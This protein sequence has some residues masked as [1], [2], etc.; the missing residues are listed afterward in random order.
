VYALTVFERE[1]RS[2]HQGP[3]FTIEDGKDRLAKKSKSKCQT[4][5]RDTPVQRR[6]ENKGTLKILKEKSKLVFRQK[7]K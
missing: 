2:R 5:V 1:I 4:R 7:K 6:P 3:S